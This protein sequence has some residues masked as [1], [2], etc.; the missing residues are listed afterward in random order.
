MKHHPYAHYLEKY[1]EF[2][3]GHDAESTIDGKRKR[4]TQL[5][6]IIY[7]LKARGKFS[8]VSP[9]YFTTKD[10]WYL[11]GH[12]KKTGAIV[13][14]LKDVSVLEGFLKFCGNNVFQKFR[15]EYPGGIPKRY[16]K[17]LPSMPYDQVHRIITYAEGIDISDHYRMHH[18][19]S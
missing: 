14:V 9:R 11:L 7:D 8:T 2:I 16:H 6:G 19:L 13:T 10:I 18:S 1:L 17:R 5:K 3:D 12:R 15:E 4:L